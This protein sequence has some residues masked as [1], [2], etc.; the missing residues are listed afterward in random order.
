M[1]KTAYVYYFG[2]EFPLVLTPLLYGNIIKNLCRPTKK[3]VAHEIQTTSGSKLNNTKQI[4]QKN[5]IDAWFEKLQEAA[6]ILIGLAKTV[7]EGRVRWG[8]WV[9]QGG[10]LIEKITKAAMLIF[11]IDIL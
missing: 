5:I 3:S 1:N 2:L 6:V 11:G 9:R 4:K 10:G 8:G 7:G